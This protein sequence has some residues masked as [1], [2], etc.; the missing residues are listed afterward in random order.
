MRRTSC[1]PNRESRCVT[2]ERLD[3]PMQKQVLIRLPTGALQPRR[4][5]RCRRGRQSNDARPVC[6]DRGLSGA[7]DRRASPHVNGALPAAL[8]R[9]GADV[10]MLLP[11]FRPLAL[12]TPGAEARRN[13]RTGVRRAGDGLS[14]GTING[15]TTYSAQSTLPRASIAPAIR[16]SVR[17][18]STGLD[19][20]LR[21]AL[22]GSIA[23]RFSDG[24]FEMAGVPTSSTGTTGTR[25]TGAGLRGGA[26]AE[27]GPA[28]C[29]RSTT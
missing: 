10:R 25:G 16:T 11:G 17:M 12:R 5:R 21:F 2:Q 8:N 7:E 20:H 27:N 9:L 26:A 29:S 15:V 18:T 28:Q 4:P 23:A 1:G 3:R 14:R 6:F 13:A 24:S 22:L 19:N